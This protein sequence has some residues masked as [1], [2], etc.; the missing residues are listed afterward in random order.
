MVPPE[1]DPGHTPCSVLIW[2]VLW[3]AATAILVKLGPQ[4]VH[5]YLETFHLGSLVWLATAAAIILRHSVLLGQTSPCST[6]TRV[7]LGK[8]TRAMAKIRPPNCTQ[9]PQPHRRCCDKGPPSRFNHEDG[10]NSRMATYWARSLPSDQLSSVQPANYLCLPAT[11]AYTA[12]DAANRMFTPHLHHPT[13]MEI[14]GSSIRHAI[15]RK[16]PQISHVSSG[17]A[18][19]MLRTIIWRCPLCNHIVWSAYVLLFFLA[20]VEGVSSY[21]QEDYPTIP[22][23]TVWNGIPNHDFRHVWFA[24]LMVGLG[25]IFQDGWTLLQVA[26]DEDLGGP[27]HPGTPDQNDASNN[28]NTRLFHLILNYID[29][30]CDLYRRVWTTFNNDGRGLY[31]YLWVFGHLPYTSREIICLEALW[32]NA[33]ISSLKIPHDFKTVF[34]WKSWC[35]T[36]GEKRN[37]T[38]NEIREKFLDGFSES[39]DSAIIPERISTANGGSSGLYT[40]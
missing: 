20:P 37:K 18:L 27:A 32:K 31:N 9:A 15:S 12:A 26:R 2:V 4:V 30:K 34:K 10:D 13:P 33:S 8:T 3:L 6:T 19:F 29:L 25:S 38:L 21:I 16:R 22:G 14:L 11:D 23:M 5:H 40:L 39:F 36:E 1:I 35:V 7:P 17:F 24:I 28:R